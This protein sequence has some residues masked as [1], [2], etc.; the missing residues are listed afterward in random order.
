MDGTLEAAEEEGA[1]AVQ[2]GTV[3]VPVSAMKK[4]FALATDP[5]PTMT[6]G[7]AEQGN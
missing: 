1:G 3:V 4:S 5:H 2:L 6:P 7:M